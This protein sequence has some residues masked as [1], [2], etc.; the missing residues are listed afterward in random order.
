[1]LRGILLGLL[2][3]LLIFL[4]GTPL[5]VYALVSGNSDPLYRAGVYCAGIVMRLGGIQVQVSGQDRIPAGQAVVYMANHQSNADAPCLFC[6]LPPVLALA[7]KEMFRIPVLGWA[8]RL[9]GFIPVDRSRRERAIEAVDEAS[10]SLRAGKSFVIF[11]EG[12]RSE[13]GRLQPLKKGGFIMALKA[14]AAIVPVSIS[15]GRKIMRKGDWAVRSGT[16]HVTFHGLIPTVNRN[17]DDGIIDEV[18]KAIAQGLT[19]DERPAG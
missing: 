7:K 8:M 15:G 4:L 9:R 12:T 5:V 19:A 18:G 17:L 2:S 14:G 13:D 10:R 16:M 3:L 1:M 6:C 11:P